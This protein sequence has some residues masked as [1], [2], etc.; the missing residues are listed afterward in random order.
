[1]TKTSML[2]LVLIGALALSACQ[3]RRADRIAFDGVFFRSSS[4]KVDGV[5]EEFQVSVGP[6]SASMDGAR[7]AG[8]H[9]ATRY[10]IRNFGSSDIR[11]L[12][13]PDA[14]DGTLTIVNDRLLLRDTCTPA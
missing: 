3:E 9:E 5:R 8:R 7:A 12:Q 2:P 10:C 6:A 14:E 13:G 4:S 11:W 1:M